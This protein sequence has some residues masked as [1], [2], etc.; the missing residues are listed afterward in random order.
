MRR[1]PIRTL[2]LMALALIV[3]GRLWWTTHKDEKPEA[4]QPPAAASGMAVDVAPSPACNS[5]ERALEAVVRKTEDPTVLAEAR[6]KVE[7]CA[8]PPARACELG[9]AL[10]VRMPL[11]EK[12]SAGRELLG[13]LCQRCPAEANTCAG[14]VTRALHGG[15]IGRQVSPEELR[16]NLENAGPGTAS[17]CEALASTA[18]APAAVTGGDLKPTYPPLLSMLAPVCAKAGHLPTALVNA[19][20][21]QRGAQAG[22]LSGLVI[23]GPA[24]IA[25]SEIT[26]AE[27]A[28]QAFDGSDRKG[29]ELSQASTPRWEADG[30]LRAQFKPPL[31]QLTALRISAKGA[32]TLRAIVRAPAGMGLRDD[33]RGTSFVNPTVCQFQGTGQWELCTLPLP[34]LEVE[35]LSIFPSD[36]KITVLEVDVQGTRTP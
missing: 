4:G 1:F 9:G 31:K 32:G 33:E 35:A 22:D 16:W 2:L 26:G 17:A 28:R 13:A 5:L 30:A 10:D 6:K 11:T 12:P 25:P 3:F 34:L 29:V 14:V 18:L 20:V 7:A 8:R 21:I 19:A 24:Y 36:P 23:A 27:N 15:L